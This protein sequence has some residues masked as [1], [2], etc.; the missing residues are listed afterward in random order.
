MEGEEV[1]DC[2]SLKLGAGDYDSI[3]A[4]QPGW[5]WGDFY[6]EMRDSSLE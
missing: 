2:V 3:S 1:L 5:G 6:F 4:W